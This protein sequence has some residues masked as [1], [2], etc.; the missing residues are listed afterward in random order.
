MD[1]A[2][3]LHSLNRIE[4]PVPVHLPDEDTAHPLVLCPALHFVLGLGAAREG[5]RFR[6]C[7]ESITS[8]GVALHRLAVLAGVTDRNQSTGL[9]SEMSS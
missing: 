9:H 3:L 6:S 7:A 2:H 5:F 1:S 8:N 4:L